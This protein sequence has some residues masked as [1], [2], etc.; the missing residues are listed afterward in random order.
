[1]PCTEGMLH[2]NSLLP[3]PLP[4]KVYGAR[5]PSLQNPGTCSGSVLKQGA[6]WSS[7]AVTQVQSPS[8]IHSFTSSRGNRTP[9]PAQERSLGVHGRASY[10]PTHTSFC[11]TSS[12]CMTS[13]P[14]APVGC[15]S[16]LCCQTL[17]AKTL[18]QPLM[19]QPLLL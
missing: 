4:F 5:Q 2:T 1:M 10:L 12:T 8:H 9:A 6:V 11:M 15:L 13:L 18:S 3:Q 14:A 16:R 19:M 17:L 7:V